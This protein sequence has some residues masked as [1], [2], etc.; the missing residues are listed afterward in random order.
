M[1]LFR[2]IYCAECGEKTNWFTRTRLGDNTYVCSKC[3]Q[4]IPSYIKKCVD[5][6]YTLDDFR[7]LKKYI[8]KSQKEYEPIFKETSSYKDIHLD[9][10]HGLLYFKSSWTD[11]IVCFKLSSILE[12]ELS[13]SPN[14]IKEGIISD[15]VSGYVLF[16]MVVSNPL[17]YVEKIIDENAKAPAKTSLFGRKVEYEN[18][19]KMTDFLINF[20]TAY[21][22]CME[23]E[24]GSIGKSEREDIINRALAL[25]MFDSLEDVTMENLKS[26][27]NKLIKAFHPDASSQSDTK[28]AQKINEAYDVLK[29]TIFNN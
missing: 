17:F 11:P 28:S 29:E 7:N 27:R 22:E 10:F 24:Y 9:A 23:K 16:H 19:K 3:T 20:H 14:K 4:D 12:F 18:P 2:E 5:G 6:I 13:F 15:K 26:Q 8:K 25:F 1:K 21:D